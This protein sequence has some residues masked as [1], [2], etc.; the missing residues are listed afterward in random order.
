MRAGKTWAVNACAALP[1]YG[2]VTFHLPPLPPGPA[3]LL[4]ALAG[5]A[6]AAWLNARTGRTGN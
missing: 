2:T 6:L 5:S 1:V 4:A 3:A